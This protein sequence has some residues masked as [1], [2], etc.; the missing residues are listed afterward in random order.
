MLGAAAGAQ[1]PQSPAP[2][3]RVAG[4]VT[5]GGIPIPGAAIVVRSGDAVQLATSTDLDG[6][7]SIQFAP[8]SSYRLSIDATGFAGTVR[9]LT[10]DG[11]PCDRTVDIQIAL[12]PR[13]AAVETPAPPAAPLASADRT[14]PASTPGGRGAGRGAS[15][16][17]GQSGQATQRFQTLNVQADAN[18]TAAAEPGQTQ[19]NEDVA[20]LL[21]PGFSPQNAQSDAI[22]ITGNGDATNLDRGLM[23]GRLQAINAGQLDPVGGLNG[24][25]GLDGSGRPGGLDGSGRPGGFGGPGGFGRGGPGGPGGFVLGGRGARAQPTYRGSATYTF[26]GSVVDSAPYQLRPDVSPTEPPF[27][28]NN[29]GA[30]FGGPLKIPGI[31]ANESR[32]T[33]FQINYSG[34][35]NNN[36]F[37][38]YATVPTD[39]MRSGNFSSSPIPL[40]DPM[41]GQPFAG[42]Q[43]P[44]N[45][46][47]PSAASLLRFIPAQNLSGDQHNYHVT[48]TAHSSSEAVSLRVVQNLS[49]SVA[50]DNRGRAGGQGGSGGTGRGGGAGGF[51]GGRFGGAGGGRSGRGTNIVLS[52]Q[53]QYRR[54][55]TEGLNVFP[56]LGGTTVNTSLAVPINL[57]VA[58]NRSMHLF[59]VNTVHSSSETTNA[60]ANTENAAG[61]AGIQYPTS[62]STDPANWGVPNLTFSGFTGVRGASTTARNDTRVTAGYT[63]LHP[64]EHHRLRLGGD[65]R[66]DASENQINSNA[67]GSFTFTGLYSSGGTTRLGSTGADFADFLLGLPQQASLQVGG[68]SRLRQRALDGFVEDNWQKNAKLTLNLGLR[69]ELARPYVEVDGR[70]ANLDAPPNLSAV[71]PVVPGATG[72]YTGSFPAGLLDTDANNLGPRVGAA[73]RLTPST[74]LRGGYSITYNSGS[75]ASIARELAGQPPFADTITTTGFPSQ[76]L[77]LAE[78]LI[79]PTPPTTNNWGVDRDYALGTIQTWNATVTHT[80]TQNWVVL[81]GYTGIKG[82]DLDILRAPTLGPGGVPISSAQPFIWESSGGH[83]LMNAANVQLQRRLAGG[84]SGALSYTLARAMDNASSLGAGGAVVAQNDK[85]LNAE[86]ALSNFDRR[87][88]LSGNLYVEL[89]WGPNRRWLKNGGVLAELVGEWAAQLT[90]TLQS[91]TPLT[92][93]VLGAASD[94]LRGVNGSLRADYNGAPIQLTDPTVDEFFNVH[95]F[96]I[97]PPGEY[98]DSSRNM[99]VGPGARQLNALFQRDLRL[100]PNR[101][102]T[103]QVNALNLLNTVQWAAVDTNINSTTFGY[104]L[105]A[106]PMRTITLTARMRF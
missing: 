27:A 71:S 74:I 36:V 44:A 5:S 35:A 57:T 4:R 15:A 97:P 61:Q 28:Q 87:H 84:I 37:D 11:P 86:Y 26:G 6:G 69:Y 58:R 20:R 64:T 79:A 29:F 17:R 23:N 72:P 90:L 94:L 53:L 13:H 52:G 49:P 3:C 82:T 101:S 70:L 62:A 25:G 95:A 31:Y 48:T 75:Y 19:D 18:G 51:G 89:P 100:S 66:F 8:N 55:E 63:W 67:R 81:A 10:L 24:S 47:D 92:A 14:S 98:G 60:F 33:N 68:V 7:Y 42:N 65:L 78:A 34:T 105:S 38:Q 93:R 99:I 21:P 76:P 80:F 40:I 16:G 30:T 32:R 39:A 22:A 59:N 73:Y 104:V 96:T 46:I 2:R 9:D 85:D 54:N 1:A 41:T 45:R 88:Q 56:D 83:S 91:G 50:T 43:I 106:K 12:A 102:L 103:L 77:T